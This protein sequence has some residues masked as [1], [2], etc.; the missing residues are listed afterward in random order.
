[1]GFAIRAGM[2]VAF[3]LGSCLL[4]TSPALTEENAAAAVTF[5]ALGT[6]GY[7]ISVF[8]AYRLSQDMKKRK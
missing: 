2:I 8:F 6:I 7:M 1:M 5:R 3:F 4:C